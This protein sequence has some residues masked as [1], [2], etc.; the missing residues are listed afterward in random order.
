MPYQ[1]IHGQKEPL[2]TTVVAAFPE[3]SGF[4]HNDERWVA[5]SCGGLVCGILTGFR[6]QQ[7]DPR[8]IGR[9][10]PECLDQA[11]VGSEGHL[12]RALASYFRYYHRWRPH[13]PLAIDCPEARP[14]FP[15]DRGAEVENPEVGGLHHHY[16]RVAA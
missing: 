2:R 9:V 6:E 13:L 5:F 15:G 1:L 4:H 16:E 14:V 12:R 10:R 3:V 7:P 11:V 8:P